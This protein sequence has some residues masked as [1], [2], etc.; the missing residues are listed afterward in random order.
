MTTALIKKCA[1]LPAAAW[2]GQSFK[3]KV[4]NVLG[5]LG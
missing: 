3:V 5:W 1:I 4:R 2:L